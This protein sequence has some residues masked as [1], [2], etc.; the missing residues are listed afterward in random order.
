MTTKDN[1]P[2]QNMA[3][4]DI[5][6]PTGSPTRL[7]A[8]AGSALVVVPLDTPPE[9]LAEM[10]AAG[11]VPLMT[12]NP[13]G[14]RIISPESQIA[15][16]DMVMAALLALREPSAAGERAVFIREL[17]TRMLAREQN[18]KAVPTEG[19]EKKL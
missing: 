6:T 7:P 4:N 11:M 2:N 15:H 5:Q 19:G 14:V 10:R 18:D 1:Q 8:S 13:A 16:S 3:E 12:D 17:H 9:C